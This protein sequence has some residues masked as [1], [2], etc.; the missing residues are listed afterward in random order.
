MIFC[1]IKNKDNNFGKEAEDQDHPH[2]WLGPDLQADHEGPD[3]LPDWWD[4]QVHTWYEATILVSRKQN[5]IVATQD[6]A[7]LN[8]YFPPGILPVPGAW[9]PEVHPQISGKTFRR[10]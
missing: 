8:L 1:F 5:S 6:T 10:Q 7:D 3:L 4:P 9:S 2:I